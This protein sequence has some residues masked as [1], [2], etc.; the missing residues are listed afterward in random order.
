MEGKE[1]GRS[2]SSSVLRLPEHC[3]VIG[4]DFRSRHSPE[5]H[6]NEPQVYDCVGERPGRVEPRANKPRPKQIVTD[7][8]HL[9][10]K[11]DLIRGYRDNPQSLFDSN[12]DRVGSM[13]L[14][15]D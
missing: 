1:E 6:G 8:A 15:D 12:G 13:E 11:S 10:S 2:G 7:R 14:A 9:E 4:H 3:R 5:W